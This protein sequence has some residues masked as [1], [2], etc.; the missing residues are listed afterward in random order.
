M[1][2]KVIRE[3]E[4]KSYLDLYANE[5]GLQELVNSIEATFAAQA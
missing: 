3:N 1:L 5:L 2:L 4:T